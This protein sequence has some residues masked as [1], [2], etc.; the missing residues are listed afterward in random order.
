[1]RVLLGVAWNLWQGVA[2]KGEFAMRRREFLASALAVGAAP[3]GA[4]RAAVAST[5]YSVS[6]LPPASRL[7]GGQVT[8]EPPIDATV[9]FVAKAD[10]ERKY[11]DI[12]R[13]FKNDNPSVDLTDPSSLLIVA[14]PKREPGAYDVACQCK[15]GDRTDCSGSGGG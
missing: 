12:L 5:Q 9:Q 6:V 2:K 8:L 1:M 13:D 7:P 15:C 10:I 3:A 4:A 11:Q 14:K